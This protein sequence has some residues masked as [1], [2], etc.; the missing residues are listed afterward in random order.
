VANPAGQYTG[1]RA[2]DVP[3]GPPAWRQDAREIG[4]VPT[5]LTGDPRRKSPALAAILSLMPGIGQVYVGYYQQGFTNIFIIAGVIAL[6]VNARS[7]SSVQH[8]LPFLGLF[9]AF[10]WLYNVVDAY[11]RAAFYNQ[12]LSG[13]GAVEIPEDMKLPKGRGS[14]VGGVALIAVGLL[15]FANTALGM[16]LDWLEQWWP[17]GL[18]LLGAYLVYPSVAGKRETEARKT[19]QETADR[20]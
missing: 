4:V 6:M 18:V 14:L 7:G 9:L 15:L 20:P 3:A 19:V 12:A 11:R 1:Q 8:L 2:P 13:V 5:T 17:M 16:S 10:F